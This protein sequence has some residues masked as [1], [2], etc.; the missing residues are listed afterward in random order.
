M[1]STLNSAR[2][3]F[4]ED[5]LWPTEPSVGSADERSWP[6]YE[7]GGGMGKMGKLSAEI[8]LLTELEKDSGGTASRGRFPQ[9]S[10]PVPTRRFVRAPLATSRPPPSGLRAVS[11]VS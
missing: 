2:H 10:S 3:D 4:S 8:K 5:R 11:P 1:A 7:F 9:Q 6:S